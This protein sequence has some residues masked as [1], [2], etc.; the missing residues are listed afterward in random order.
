MQECLQALFRDIQQ[1][2]LRL[3][4]RVDDTT[5]LVQEM[6]AF[7]YLQGARVQWA[8]SDLETRHKVIVE[9]FDRSQSPA[10]TRVDNQIGI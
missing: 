1:D 7:E 9:P 6:Q 4:I 8:V 10:T 2:V 3:D 5:L